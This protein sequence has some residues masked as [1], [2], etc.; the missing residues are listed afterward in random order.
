VWFDKQVVATVRLGV[1]IVRNAT[2]DRVW[3]RVVILG[4]IENKAMSIGT[5][6]NVLKPAAAVLVLVDSEMEEGGKKVIQ[7]GVQEEDNTDQETT[8]TSNRVVRQ[9]S[10]DNRLTRRGNSEEHYK[11]QGVDRSSTF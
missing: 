4:M 6:M 1:A 10:S 8:T 2:K 5:A 11:G 9:T 3:I 7:L